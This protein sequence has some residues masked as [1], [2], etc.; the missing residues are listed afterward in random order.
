M[1]RSTSLRRRCPLDC[2]LA[3]YFPASNPQRF[4]YMF[5]E[6]LQLP[7]EDRPAAANCLWIEASHRVEDPV[8]GIV[9]IVDHLRQQVTEVECELAKTRGEIAFYRAQNAVQQSVKQES[10][11]RNQKLLPNY[12]QLN[13][14]QLI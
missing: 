13:D 7:I 11:F 12:C 3:P 14:H 10:F 4:A 1:S 9:K 6:S 8:Y 2:V 5:I